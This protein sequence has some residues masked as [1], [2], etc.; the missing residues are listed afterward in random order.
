MY[1]TL[2]LKATTAIKAT[3]LKKSWKEVKLD[4]KLL[5]NNIENS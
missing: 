2:T 4:R 1:H 3:L 5:T